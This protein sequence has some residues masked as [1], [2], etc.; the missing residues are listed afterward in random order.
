MLVNEHTFYY[1]DVVSQETWVLFVGA[2]SIILYG[3]CSHLHPCWSLCASLNEPS[4]QTAFG[5]LFVGRSFCLSVQCLMGEKFIAQCFARCAICFLYF[6][7]PGMHLMNKSFN[8]M[9]VVYTESYVGITINEGC[10]NYARINENILKLSRSL[11][12]AVNLFL[13]L[14]GRWLIF[15]GVGDA[16][17]KAAAA[18]MVM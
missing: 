7:F 1:V 2:F 5:R 11:I 12:C 10:M 4:A 13:N 17:G 14:Y 15:A 18:V 8:M 3:K 6:L 16:G 9:C